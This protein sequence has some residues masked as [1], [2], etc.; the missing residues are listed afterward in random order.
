MLLIIPAW[1]NDRWLPPTP[2]ALF[3]LFRGGSV[4]WYLWALTLAYLFTAATIRLPS[5]LAVL[6]ALLT[7][8]CLIRSGAELRGAFGSLGNYLP[9]YVMGARYGGPLTRLSSLHDV[10]LIGAVIVAYFILLHSAVA[11]PGVE[12]ARHLAGAA[13]GILVAAQLAGIWPSHMAPFAWLGRRTLPIYVLHFP[14]VALLGCAAL[15]FG[16]WEPRAA[17]LLLFLPMLAA[18][19]LAASLMLFHLAE[20]MGLAWAF[21]MKRA[22]KAHDGIAPAEMRTRPS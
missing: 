20:R 10:R 11:F 18:A 12:L 13:T 14:I 9:L 3:E 16:P 15:R 17:M 19:T 2:G 4:L 7:G 21:A 8:V 22:G 1:P 5:P 6:T